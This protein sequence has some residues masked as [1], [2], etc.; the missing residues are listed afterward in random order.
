L[1][2]TFR[3]GRFFGSEVR[4]YGTVGIVW[5]FSMYEIGKFATGG[6]LEAL[7][8][9]TIATVGLYAIV[10]TH[11]MGH[12]LAGRAW[13]IRTP[14]ITLSVFGGLAHLDSAV[15]GPKADVLVALAGPATHLVWL[16][17]LWPASRLYTGWSAPDGWTYDPL[18]FFLHQGVAANLGLMVFNLLPVYPLDG[19]RA[20]RGLL[21]TR[22]NANRATLIAAK[23]GMLGGA[24]LVVWGLMQSALGG[25]ILMGIGLMVMFT[26]WNAHRVARYGDG[27]Y[28]APRDPWAFDDEAWRHGESPAGDDGSRPGWFERRRLARERA[29]EETSRAGRERDAAELDRLLARV[30]ESGIAGLTAKERA[31]LQR[32]SEA[33]RGR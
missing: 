30:S 9:G 33:Q 20:F 16:A 12:A 23:V 27:P 5:L 17:V 21:A 18:W 6:L 19:G 2:W 8:L 29:R 32:L 10:W 4:V 25:V 31:T 26:A 11:E 24:G 22:M 13:S 28:G 3:L 7:T 1:S 15:P 14:T